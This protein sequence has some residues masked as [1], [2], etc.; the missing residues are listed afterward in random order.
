M[1]RSVGEAGV[2][3]LKSPSM[4]MNAAL[5]ETVGLTTV[6]PRAVSRTETSWR[7][8]QTNIHQAFATLQADLK[9]PNASDDWGQ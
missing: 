8:S 9:G 2:H 7:S 3:L 4:T 1:S 5:A 6:Q